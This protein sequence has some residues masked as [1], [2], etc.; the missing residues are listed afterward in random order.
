MSTT[1]ISSLFGVPEALNKR[2]IV[3]KP[4]RLSDGHVV[5]TWYE[6]ISH[7]VN[8]FWGAGADCNFVL[9]AKAVLN[10]RVYDAVV[11]IRPDGSFAVRRI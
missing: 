6:A 5:K 3:I 10:D 4:T 9:E 8:Y 2:M 11:E 7:L 1:N